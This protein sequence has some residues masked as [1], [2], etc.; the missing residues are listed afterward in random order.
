MASA[1]LNSL[2]TELSDDDDNKELKVKLKTAVRKRAGFKS[3][4]TVA[5]K[6]LDEIPEDALTTAL[7]EQR[8]N[9]IFVYLGKVDLINDEVISICNEIGLTYEDEIISNEIVQQVT[10]KGSITDRLANIKDRLKSGSDHDNNNKPKIETQVRVPELKCPTFDGKGQDKMEFKN[11]LSQFNN[12]IDSVGTLSDSSKLTYLRGYVKDYAFRIISH[13]S[14]NDDNYDI[15]VQ[16]LKDEFLDKEYIIDESFKMLINNYPKYDENFCNVKSYINDCRALLYELKSYNMDLLEV[17]TAGCKFISHI[18][19]MKLP[20]SFRRE[21]VH[22]VETNYPTVIDIFGNYNDIIKTLIRTTSGKNKHFKGNEQSV[23]S[24]SKYGSNPG[25]AQTDSNSSKSYQNDHDKNKSTLENFNTGSVAERVKHCKFCST[26]GHLMVHCEKYNSYD[27]RKSRCLEL[28]ICNFCS[29]NKHTGDTCPGK[30][31]KLSFACYYCNSK[32]HISALCPKG[33]SQKTTSTNLCINM[34]SSLS[35]QNYLLPIM[36]IKFSKGHKSCDVRVLL[37]FGSHRSYISESV[38]EYLECDS[39]NWVTT[40]YDVKTFIGSYKRSFKE[41]MMDIEIP[42]LR[43][44]PLPVLVDSEFDI[45]LG[46]NKFKLAINNLQS[47]GYKLADPF[48]AEEGEEITLQGLLGVDVLQFI[49]FMNRVNCMNGAAWNTE[50]GYVPFGNI[51]HFLYPH[52]MTYDDTESKSVEVNFIIALKEYGSDASATKVNFVLDPKKTYFSPLETMFP[53]SEVEHC[54]ENMFGIETVGCRNSVEDA[55]DFDQMKIQEFEN[56]IV[57]KD[58]KYY[59]NLP[60]YDDVIK[61]VPSNYNIAINI[62]GKV[63]DKLKKNNMLEAYQ[64]VF[65]KQ[66]EDGII[67]KVEV[68]PNTFDKHIWIPHRPIVK[69]EPNTTTKI[70]PVFNC[71]LKTKNGPSVNDAAYAGVNLMSDLTKL[72]LYFRSNDLVMVSDIKQAFLQIML[73]KDEDKNRFSFFMMENDKLVAYRY[74]TIIFGFNASPFILNFVIKHHAKLYPADLCTQILKSNFY[75]DNLIITGNDIESLKKTYQESLQ[76]ME[77]GGF[78]LRSWNSNSQEIRD[79]V[80]NDNNKALHSNDYEKV[81]G[82]KYLFEGDKLRLSETFLDPGANTKRSILSQISKVFDP[83]GLYLPVTTR[84]KLL[85][86]NLWSK[87]LNWDEEISEEDKETWNKLREDYNKMFQISI[88]RKCIDAD[89]ENSLYVFCDSSK[90]CHGFAIYN[91][92]DGNSQLVFAKAKVAPLKPRSLPTMEL[93]AVHQALECL[94]FVL[95][96][97][98]N[99][100]FKDIYIIVDSQVVLTWILSENVKTKNLF[101]KNRVKDISLYIKEIYNKFKLTIN[102]KFV[103][104]DH[105]A[106]D[107]LT[108]GLSLKEFEKKMEFWYHGPSWLTECPINWPSSSLNCLSEE[109][110]ETVN[111]SKLVNFNTVPVVGDYPEF[112]ILKYS[113]LNFLLG[114]TRNVLLF[115]SGSQKKE[116]DRTLESAKIFWIKRMQREKF[117]KELDYLEN[118]SDGNFQNRIPDLINRLDLFLDDK[119][120]IRS[121]GRIGKSLVYDYDVINPVLLAKDHH[122]TRLVV[123]FYHLK[124]K[125]LGIQTTLTAVRLAG[126]WIPKMR[127][128]IKKILSDCVTCQK[129]NNLAFRYPKMTNLPKH[130]VN[131]VKPFKHTGVDY[132]GHVFVKDTDG[133][134]KKMYLLIFTCLNVRAVHIELIPDMTTRSF[135]LAFLR[136]VNLYGI[137]THLYSDNARS[138]IAGYNLL[139]EAMVT[140]E[141]G[142]HFRNYDIKHI[143]IPAYSAWVG[144]TWERLI[145]TIK[146]CLYKTVGRSKL[147]YF[148]LLTILSDIVV[149]V[150]SR[151]LTYRSSNDDL[152]IITPNSFLKFNTNPFLMLRQSGDEYIWEDDPPSRSTLIQAIEARNKLFDHFKEVWYNQYL[153]SLRGGYQ[154]LHE[155]RWENRIKA[156]DVVL[157][158]LPNKPRPYWLL[159]RVQEV[160][161]GFDDKIRSV[162]L[163]R[164]DGQIVHHSINHLY[165]LELSLTH[166]GS[167]VSG[168][169]QENSIGGEEEVDLAVVND[170]NPVQA[171]DVSNSGLLNAIDNKSQSQGSIDQSSGT[172]VR[173]KRTAAKVCEQKMK[174]WCTQIQD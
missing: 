128:A 83:L 132:T 125:H 133:N 105:N 4:V 70:R 94:P 67:E 161:L 107:L 58:N 75:V 73:A 74:R 159:G 168:E 7:F 116:K 36:K 140:D 57:L 88:S 59:V 139:E 69:T 51:S 150:N 112:N 82:Y 47:E 81:L 19:F 102:F 145:R 33:K 20:Y 111:S 41:S 76:R 155:S 23:R 154:N 43:D 2:Y 24:K 40:D 119:G 164:G 165:P 56:S 54:L 27:K 79:M 108:H 138:F 142:E 26:N 117:S 52:Q 37:D 9:D 169:F 103:P 173:P 143:R 113:S 28:G 92:C 120:I 62:L 16:L 166:A 25:K 1:N 65:K 98:S 170:D 22:K 12:C 5:I 39:G 15:A 114:V 45:Q 136:F 31:G 130:R 44:L 144:S 124:N 122:L 8:Q 158:K 104:T 63:V 60:W 153:L 163:K 68:D 93:M 109:N 77:E 86:R 126:F 14:I 89:K 11:F 72:M 46:V 35:R 121:R 17:D 127:Q 110:K 42:G 71:S 157:V 97:Y 78:H 131:L 118:I 96:S 66:L 167:T 101:A 152:E 34:G 3:R 123:E 38:V 29:S 148:E 147:D 10:Y 21:L 13:L 87:K 151:P 53:E 30:Q 61:N 90:L 100:N 115:V 99:I 49:P 55:S 48:I 84:G 32:N 106:A 172:N 129:F 135:I 156:G 171:H 64:N 146:N 95:E 137:P 134:N 174:K 50:K 141:F 18:I 85:M 160:I 149:A 80:D 162:R 6:H 91:V